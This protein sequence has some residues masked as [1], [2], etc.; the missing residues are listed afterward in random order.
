MEKLNL[1]EIAELNSLEYIE[2]T[3]GRNGYPQAIKSAIIGFDTFEDAEKLAEEHNLSIEFFTKKDGWPL[4]CRTGNNAHEA[5]KNSSDDYGDNY[6]QFDK[7]TEEEF[8]I[9]EVLPVIKAIEMTDN[10]NF[11]FLETFIKQ[12]KEL[13]NKIDELEENEIV[14]TCQ[15]DY[16]DTIKEN[17][18]YFYHDTK[19]TTIGLIDRN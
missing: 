16:Y 2:T 10:N 5:M 7:M 11:D 8:L 4:W 9:N 15:C 19:H 18:M 17:S 14:I 12:Q 6:S 13:F 3:S 1:S